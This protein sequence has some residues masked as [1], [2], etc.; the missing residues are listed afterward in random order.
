MRTWFW[1]AVL[2][3]GKMRWPRWLKPMLSIIFFGCFAAGVVYAL[4]VLQ[5][6]K[7]R[8]ESPHVHAHSTH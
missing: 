6:A 1:L 7:E 2:P 4:V 8:S 3:N 5:A